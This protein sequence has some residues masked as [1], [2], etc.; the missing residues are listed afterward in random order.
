[1][2]KVLLLSSLFAFG[3]AASYGTDIVAPQTCAGLN[4]TAA[5]ID[6]ANTVTCELGD[7]IFSNFSL[8]GATTGTITISGG[9]TLYTLQFDTQATPI[10]TAFTLGFT[11]AVDTAIAPANFITQVQ[12]QMFT[13]NKAGGNAIPNASTAVVTHTPGGA[14]NLNATVAQNQSGSINLFTQTEGVSFAY[15]PHGTGQLSGANFSISQ[16]AVPEPV[17]LSL[18]GLG[19]LGLGFFGRRRLKA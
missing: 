18:T 15:D 3:A 8:N 6:V 1:M 4:I 11:V 13:Q 10:T 19:L 9:G 5:M 12:D 14:V 7:K 2:K 16:T 17:S